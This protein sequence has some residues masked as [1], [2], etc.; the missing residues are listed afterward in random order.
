MDILTDSQ[1]VSQTDRQTEL[2]RHIDKK[3]HRIVTYRHTI[4]TDRT[5]RGS[6]QK[7]TGAARAR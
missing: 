2:H 5:Y 1:S 4:Q 6:T 7:Q 3:R